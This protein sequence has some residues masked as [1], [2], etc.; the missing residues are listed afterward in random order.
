MAAREAEEKEEQRKREADE[1]RELRRLEKLRVRE[2]KERERIEKLL[3]EAP[4]R[5]KLIGLGV[6]FPEDKPLNKVNLVAV[7]TK[8]GI[9]GARGLTIPILRREVLRRLHEA[10]PEPP[11][12]D[13]LLGI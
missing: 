3:E 6:A 4:I 2:V 12:G 11:E 9:A 7:A 10:A 5:E 1:D 13:E 8:I